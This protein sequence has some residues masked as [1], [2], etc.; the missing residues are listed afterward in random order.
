MRIPYCV[1][2]IALRFYAIRN[3]LYVPCSLGQRGRQSLFANDADMDLRSRY[4]ERLHADNDEN[5]Q[6]NLARAANF[7]MRKRLTFYV[8]RMTPLKARPTL[9]LRRSPQTTPT[10]I[11][12][13][14]SLGALFM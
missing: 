1:M 5:V 10:S 6:A 7:V 12:E 8:L 3:T 13:A 14:V 11:Y 2:R 9:A 4:H